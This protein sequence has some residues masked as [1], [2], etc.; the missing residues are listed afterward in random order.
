LKDEIRSRV[1]NCARYMLETGATVRRCAAEFGVSKTTVHKD[2]RLRLPAIDPLLSAGV[3]RL[4][5]DNRRE[6]HLRGGAATR[7]K[8]RGRG[9]RADRN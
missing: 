5:D 8:F 2:M 4:L 9:G 6:R 1:L 7:Q 3:H